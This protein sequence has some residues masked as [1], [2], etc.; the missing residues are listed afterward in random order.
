MDVWRIQHPKVRDY[1][2]RSAVHGTYSR[3]DL[4]LVDHGSLKTV[5]S[6]DIGIVT[7][8]DHAPVSINLN[9][10]GIQKNIRT[11]K[12]NEDLFQDEEVVNKIKRE[13][14]LYFKENSSEH[15]SEALVWEAHKAYIR[16]IRNS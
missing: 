14:E 4:F 13:L 2:F 10:A 16:G 1:S 12:L 5:K 3:I 7:L 9:I 15:L 11:W 8:S 6:S